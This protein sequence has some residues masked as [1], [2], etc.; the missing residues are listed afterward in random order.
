MTKSGKLFLEF[1]VVR[2]KYVDVNISR[3]PQNKREQKEIGN[4]NGDKRSFYAGIKNKI[5]HDKGCNAKRHIQCVANIHGAIKERR[6]NFIFQITMTASFVHF[7]QFRK[8]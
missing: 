2:H 8:M 1:F 6:L 5:R 4:K 7:Y 3:P